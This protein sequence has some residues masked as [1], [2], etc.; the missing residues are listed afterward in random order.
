M[1][2]TAIVIG[3]LLVGSVFDFYSTGRHTRSSGLFPLAI[4]AT[5][6]C[7]RKRDDA[8]YVVWT[9]EYSVGITQIDEDHQKRLHLINQVQA[10][11]YYNTGRRFK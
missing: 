2:L 9:D 3:I 7:V 6:F 11:T 10:A 5:V 8:Q 4:A 1:A